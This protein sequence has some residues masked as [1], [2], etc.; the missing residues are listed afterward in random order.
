MNLDWL[1]DSLA[2]EL[3][4]SGLLLSIAAESL[5]IPL[6]GVYSIDVTYVD[7]STEQFTGTG[8]LLID[9]SIERHIKS[10]SG[11]DSQGNI[12]LDVNRETGTNV[13]ELI[14][15]KDGVTNGTFEQLYEQQTYTIAGNNSDFIGL[16][17]FA[18]DTAVRGV[19]G[20]LIGE[21]EG[22]DG[23]TSSRIFLNLLTCRLLSLVASQGLEYDAKSHAQAGV[24]I[25][26]VFCYS[27]RVYV[28]GI[29]LGFVVGDDTDIER[30]FVRGIGRQQ[31]ANFTVN[32]KDSLGS[33][34]MVGPEVTLNVHNFIQLN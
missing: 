6:V 34:G 29:I 19:Q 30:C 9:G 33:V 26:Q 32:I 17:N 16:A 4:D 12:F 3:T 20:N 24:S 11:S 23:N 22:L 1:N 25:S 18:S 21:F 15:N 5:S 28:R 2:D 27:L 13:P 7:D 14:Q 31:N 8:T 10:I